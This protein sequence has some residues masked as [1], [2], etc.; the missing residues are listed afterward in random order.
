MNE[1]YNQFLFPLNYNWAL[2]HWII[3]TIIPNKP[4]ALPKISMISI[5]T[6]VSGVWASARAHPEPVIP[7]HTLYIFI[8]FQIKINYPQ[9]KLDNPTDKP[10]ENKLYA[11]NDAYNNFSFNY[12]KLKNKLYF[13]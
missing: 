4:K 12:D 5:F 2:P 1:L 8:L 11:L 10:T 3:P 6:N 13:L 7:T 9:N